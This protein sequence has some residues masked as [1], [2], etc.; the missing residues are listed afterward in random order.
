ME[1]SKE[2]QSRDLDQEATYT[3]R[4]DSLLCRRQQRRIV[5]SESRFV[6]L[7]NTAVTHTRAPDL[8]RDHAA[9]QSIS[10]LLW[11]LSSH[12]H[13]LRRAKRLAPAQH[14]HAVPCLFE[15]NRRHQEVSEISL[16]GEPADA[17]AQ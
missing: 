13:S 1:G 5:F 9:H 14:R 7:P 12:C 15:P 11:T 8:L 16:W 6:H 4:R 3:F 2:S 10:A 17:S